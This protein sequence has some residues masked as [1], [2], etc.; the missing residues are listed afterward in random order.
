VSIGEIYNICLDRAVTLNR[1]IELNAAA[2][3][4]KATINYMTV[5]AILEKYGDDVH[6]IG[7]RFLATHMC[8]DISKAKT[9]LDYQ[10]HCTV[11]EAIIETARWAA[12]Q[13]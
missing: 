12:Q 13:G 3:D 7:L 10:P 9:Q 6:E 2:L 1:Y 5:D 4:R 8:Y 11:E